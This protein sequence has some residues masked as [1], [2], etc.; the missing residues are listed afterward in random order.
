MV[1]AGRGWRLKPP[2]MTA[3]IGLCS[4]RWP[5]GA[6]TMT[7]TGRLRARRTTPTVVTEDNTEEDED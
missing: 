7:E 3:R 1:R 6:E 2:A 5:E 4:R